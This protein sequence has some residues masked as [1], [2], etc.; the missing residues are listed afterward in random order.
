MLQTL[1][2]LLNTP[3]HPLVH[4]L[5]HRLPYFLLSD[6]SPLSVLP[7]FSYYTVCIFPPEFDYRMCWD[8]W[9]SVSSSSSLG[10]D[11]SL[12]LETFKRGSRVP[13]ISI[14]G[15][16]FGPDPRREAMLFAL[17]YTMC[18]HVSS[19]NL[20]NYNK[21]SQIIWCF[22]GFH[23]ANYALSE[24]R[25]PART[26]R[27][28][29]P[30]SLIVVAAFYLLCNIAYYAAASKE[31]I[32]SSGRLVAALLFKN[33]WGPKAEIFL[34]AFIALS[35]LGNVLSVVC[36]FHGFRRNNAWAFVKSF[37]QGRVNQVLGKDG[38]LPFS[39]FWASSWPTKAPLAGLG[40][41]KL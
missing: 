29:G 27:I 16:G 15:N 13:E 8:S 24:V 5:P 34:N 39:S 40:L 28:A 25:N 3:S 11:S 6:S 10:P 17:A 20:T 33:V 12:S 1:S 37:S 26:L 38:I 30:L 4:L 21:F 41:S 23:S 22:N 14:A 31:E 36:L 18:V 9:R 7:E 32:T 19:S 35:A 2:F